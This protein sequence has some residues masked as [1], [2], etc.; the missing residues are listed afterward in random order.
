LEEW[1]S[2]APVNEAG[3]RYNSSDF[4][5]RERYATKAVARRICR[6]RLWMD[7]WFEDESFWRE[8][9][10]FMFSDEAF[11]AASDQ[12]ERIVA[13]TGVSAGRVL[14]LGCGP[15]RH[16]VPLALKGLSVTAVDASP[17]LLGKA[18]E[19]A[20]RADVEVDFISAD[21]RAFCRP[22][23]FDLAISMFSSFGYFA[24]RSDDRQVADNL[25]RS[26]RSGG[27]ALIDVMSKEL[28]GRFKDTWVTEA[29]NVT[30]VE[31]HE[32]VDDWTRIKSEWILIRDGSVQR[33]EYCVRIYSGQELSDLLRGVGFDDVT[34]YGGLD[35]RAY[36]PN[37]SRLIA[38]ARKG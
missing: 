27:L 10:R 16:T 18:K 31:R 19:H 30:K 29:E 37:A 32:I 34:L 25:H 38:L 11:R 7:A 26:L 35:G 22:D 24:D 28:T 5:K 20:S 15:G 9:Y 36:G 23:A 6:A 3:R 17:F 33:F 2:N 12:V 13:L 1:Q 14:D 4:G 21:M 8:G